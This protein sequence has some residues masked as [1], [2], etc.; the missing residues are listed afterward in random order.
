[1]G[2]R[3]IALVAPPTTPYLSATPIAIASSA[4]AGEMIGGAMRRLT[5]RAFVGRAEELGALATGLERAAAGEPGGFLVGGE[6]GVGKTRLGSEV[7]ARAAAAGARVTVGGCVE[8]TGGAAPL[9]PVIEGLRRVG[10]QLG[11][12]EWL[13]LVGDARPELARL[14]PELGGATQ[15]PDRA[16]AQSRLFELL[17]GLLR[18]VADRAP[19]VWIVEDAHWAD[20]S[21]RDLLAFLVRNLRDERILLVTTFR[22][23]E[24]ERSEALRPWLS[25]LSRADGVERID[26][27]RFAR[28]ELE[29]LLGEIL[30]APPSRD[31]AERVFSRS[32]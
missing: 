31:L 32:G 24:V 4:L 2:H 30:S 1:M 5:S 18:R 13:R 9:L 26:L 15:P 21:T 3:E 14:L 16:R 10:E 17:L 11:W 8:L 7:G 19:L 29:A 12:G 27:A 25:W 20:A 28:P 22:D 23:D 6:A